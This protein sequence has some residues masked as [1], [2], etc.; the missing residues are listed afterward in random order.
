ML[1]TVN[2]SLVGTHPGFKFGI[3]PAYAQFSRCIFQAHVVHMLTVIVD[4]PIGV[5]RA[6][7]APGVL[8][9]GRHMRSTYRVD[10]E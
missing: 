3:G 6:I 10:V 8:V 9:G 5:L 4:T 2:N 1:S 7:D